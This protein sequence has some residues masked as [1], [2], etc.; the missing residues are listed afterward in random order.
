MRPMLTPLIF[1]CVASLAACG[2][3][4]PVA[5]QA[6]AP[7]PH[8]EPSRVHS[9]TSAEAQAQDAAL[10]SEQN[11]NPPKGPA[12]Q[13]D[14]KCAVGEDQREDFGH[15][16]GLKESAARDAVSGDYTV[17][18]LGRDGK[19]EDVDTDYDP[20]RLNI[21]VENGVVVFVSIG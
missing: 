13:A 11:A 19:C 3:S 20:R 12:E 1:C 5:S 14:S 21:V 15:L 6:A 4:S 10:A 18:V 16:I 2:G 9:Q 8:A 17:R 7:T